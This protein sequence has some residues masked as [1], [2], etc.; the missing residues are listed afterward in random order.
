M[1]LPGL[2]ARSLLN[3]RASVALTVATIA[4]A[5]ALLVLVEQMRLQLREGFYRSVSGTDLIVGAPTSPVQLL[6]FSVFGIGN[7]SANLD[8]SRY[9]ELAADP[10]VEWAVPIALGDGY[11][12]YRVVGTSEAMFRHYRYAGGQSLQFASGSGFDDL[13]D[14]VIGAAAAH[15][16]GLAPGDSIVLS[17]GGGNVS[18]HRHEAQPFTIRG[19][20]AATGTPVDQAIYIRIDAHHAVHI[21]WDRGMPEPARML[22]PD[23]ARALAAADQQHQDAEHA[24]EAA[25]HADDDPVTDRAAGDTSKLDPDAHDLATPPP[26]GI[27]LEPSQVSAV[28]LGL[29][30]RAAA[31]GLQYRLNQQRERPLLAILPGLALQQL[32]RITG[33]AEQILRVVSGLVVLAGLMGMLTA[34]LASLAERRREMAILRA[35]GARPWQVAWLLLVEA[36][37]LTALGIAAGL[38]LA[39]AAQLALAPWL[40]NQFGIA[41]SPA[42]PAAWQWLV[43]GGI[44]ACGLLVAL[45]PAVM[46]YRRSLADGM[47]IRS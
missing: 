42:W 31:L 38:L 7:P 30:T 12:G 44:W 24:H 9:L 5:I 22:G 43:L 10:L 36:G 40:L 21:G 32:W 47:Q 3:R 6:L 26:P 16:I 14:A 27:G 11:H 2:A 18:L 34:L 15:R 29:K 17:H 13:F 35:C 41:L 8:Y 25:V 46:V 39:F 28:L 20:L 45:L 33:L 1:T 23:Q 4:I 19:V 37:L